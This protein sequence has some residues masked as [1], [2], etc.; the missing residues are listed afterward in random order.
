MPRSTNHLRGRTGLQLALLSIAYAAIAA[1]ISLY[2]LPA[3]S[4]LRGLPLLVAQVAVFVG[5]AAAVAYS[6][7]MLR[8]DENRRA[9]LRTLAAGMG[10]SYGEDVSD[11]VW[12]GSVDEQ[13]ERTARSSRDLLDARDAEIPFDSVERT[14]VVGDREGATVHR[15]R[16]VRI[17]LAAEAPRISLRSRR[18]GGALSLLPRRPRGRSELTLE[19][20]FSDVFEVSVPAGYETDALYLLTPDLMAILLDA[21]PDL[22][23]E[24]VDNTLHV[25]FPAID[26]T[27]P[28]EA[29][30]FLTAIAALHERFARRTALY[31]DDRAASLDPT[32]YRRAGDTLAAQARTLA[33]RTRVW[34]VVL[35][36][37]TPLVPLII[38]AVSLHMLG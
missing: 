9:R 30:R 21:C 29:R 4:G 13:I 24:L 36:V 33:T 31:R 11:R 5:G 2:L 7:V 22:D 27:D 8:R 38:A 17:P 37:M 14:V 19:G 34:P 16:A 25:Y 18:G 20:N 23:L 15:L 12:G 6:A 28:R 32:A 10:W 26:L 1:P 3:G 35:A